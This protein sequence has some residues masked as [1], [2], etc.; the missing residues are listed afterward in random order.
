MSADMPSTS[1]PSGHVPDGPLDSATWQVELWP[2]RSLS[3]HGLRWFLISLAGCFGVF[4]LMTALSPGSAA[5]PAG[6]AGVLLVVLAFI[7]AVF[8]CVVWAF[9]V[10]NRDGRYVERLRFAGGRLVIEAE[11]PKRPKRCWEFQPYWTRV[12][13]RDT[14]RTENQLILRQQDRAVAIGGFL[15]P[16]ERAELADEIRG[17]LRRFN[18]ARA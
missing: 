5:T 6:L 11:H 4:L 1:G 7:V 10:N 15:T 9:A 8:V 18:A 3:R 12:L 16:E 17:A 13:M 14:R 2:N